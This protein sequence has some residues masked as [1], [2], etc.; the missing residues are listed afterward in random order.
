MLST[1]A[2]PA[3]ADHAS[4]E[5]LQQRM[6]GTVRNMEIHPIWAPD[7]SALYLHEDRQILRVDTASGK[8][9][10]MIDYNAIAKAVDGDSPRIERFSITEKGDF[11]C[12]VQ[13]GNHYSS[14]HIDGSKIQPVAPEDVPFALSPRSSSESVRSGANG[15]ET[16]IIFIN[17][18][19]EPVQLFWAD[20]AGI[21][22]AY[23]TVAPGD[24][25]RQHTFAG[26]AWVA[27]PLA[28]IA[29]DEPAI[30]YLGASPPPR[31]PHPQHSDTRKWD[32]IFRD[33]NLFVKNRE[34]GKETQLT[35]DGTAGSGYGRPA[36]ESPDGRYLVAMR[37]TAGDD[38]HID[39]I[40]AAPGDQ[41]QPRTRSI[42]YPKPGDRIEQDKP[43]VFDLQ[44]MKPIAIDNALFSN[45]WAV[46]DLHW[47]ADS[48]RLYFV[49]N[50]RGHQTARLLAVQAKTGKVAV[51]AEEK[52]ETFIDWTN[53]LKVQYLDGSD[54]AIWMSERS[55]WNH[56]YLID[57]KTGKTTPITSGDWVVRNIE[58]IDEDNR[59]ILFRAGGVYPG[60]DPYYLQYGRVSFDGSK[61]TWLTKANG[62]HAVNFSPKGGYYVDTWSRINHPPV[63]E[64]H[65]YADGKPVKALA[66][67]DC[68]D[69]LKV[70]PYL[71]EPFVAKGRDGK[72]DIYGVIFRPSDFD[73]HK[74]YP[75]I[76]DIYAGP[77]DF[78]VPKEF[79]PYHA[80]QRLAELGFVV[81]K[82]DGMG[83]NWRSKQF[84]DV[85][86]K[87]LKDAG[88]PDRITWMKAA[89]K[90]YP[91]MDLSRVGIFGTSAGAQSA[92]RAVIDHADF[93][94]AAAADCG[95]HDNRVDKMWWNEQWMGWPVDESYVKSSN[96]ADAHKLGGKLLLTVGA[97]DS[98][99]DPSSTMQVVEELIKADKDFE[100]MV[101]PSMGHGAGMGPYGT[102]L[103]ED[104]FIRYLQ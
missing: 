87:N 14:L 102:R 33:H 7:D 50:E 80:N 101:F 13:S 64:L 36:T 40:E 55:G 100:L 34:T 43:C 72:T 98:N 6:N 59:E 103:R 15:R 1:L 104:F 85:C 12:L 53:K 76:E 4:A 93:Y 37:K 28:F 60:M 68:T 52:S 74:K 38:R 45:P 42:P 11:I 71:P 82:I 70:H 16:A 61:L 89:A 26:H 21:R 22:Q 18:T 27:G 41:L 69:L 56:L 96:V 32:T 94:K 62:T 9:R 35:T 23:N 44:T 86:W 48:K 84:H 58:R 97:M 29:E 90:K 91:Y 88:F 10:P 19:E 31:E 99:V 2:S 65:R 54:E 73:P 25:Y 63:H 83:T 95:C 78:F 75:M 66:K 47:S 8:S 77:Q 39:L 67:A 20:S 24:A 79:K 17:N 57:C 46:S 30:A 3:Q 49:Y 81:V 92:L 5:T 51:V